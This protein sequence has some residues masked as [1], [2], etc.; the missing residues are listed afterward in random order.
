M[1]WLTLKA[2]CET[3]LR[4]FADTGE[5]PEHFDVIFTGDL[6]FVGRT[7]LLQLLKE[8]ENNEA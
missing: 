6:G 7:L 3:I 8:E 1:K 5:K 2:A 4:Y